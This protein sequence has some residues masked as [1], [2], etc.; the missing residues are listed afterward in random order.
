MPSVLVFV[1]SYQQQLAD[2][3]RAGIA[4]ETGA[5]PAEASVCEKSVE[6]LAKVMALAACYYSSGIDPAAAVI[7]V[8]GPIVNAPTKDATG[9]DDRLA[10]SGEREGRF[11]GTER[12]VEG[13]RKLSRRL[14]STFLTSFLVSAIGGQV[15]IEDLAIAV[16]LYGLYALANRGGKDE[17][18]DDAVEDILA[19]L[20]KRLKG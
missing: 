2:E 12:M 14:G 17:S 5:L 13:T 7:E 4:E 18:L 15:R 6:D 20:V 16:A 10:A 11:F 19:D 8:F 9:W 3:I 1:D